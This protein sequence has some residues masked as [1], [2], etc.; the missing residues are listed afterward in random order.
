MVQD[1]LQKEEWHKIKLHIRQ[2]KKRNGDKFVC[3]HRLE[4]ETNGGSG[5]ENREKM[6]DGLH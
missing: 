3:V 4:R 5:C 2:K 6:R 1:K